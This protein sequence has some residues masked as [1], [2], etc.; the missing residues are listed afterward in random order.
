MSLSLVLKGNKYYQLYSFK[1]SLVMED[2]KFFMISL[3]HAQ[4]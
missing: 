2:S 4:K 3:D 1:K